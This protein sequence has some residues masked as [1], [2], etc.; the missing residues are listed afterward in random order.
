MTE[1]VEGDA[2]F[3]GPAM[4]RRGRNV[5]RGGELADREQICTG[6]LIRCSQRNLSDESENVGPAIERLAGEPS[7]RR[8]SFREPLTVLTARGPGFHHLLK[9]EQGVGTET[10][11]PQPAEVSP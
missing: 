1:L 5:E 2:L 8:E 7:G 4:N 10:G 11:A 6:L 9:R 3:A